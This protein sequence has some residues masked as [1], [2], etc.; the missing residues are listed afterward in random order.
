MTMKINESWVLLRPEC[1]QIDQQRSI[2][3]Q[4][5]QVE[6]TIV[7][8]FDNRLDNPAVSGGNEV[9]RPKPDHTATVSDDPADLEALAV[10][11]RVHGTAM[12]SLVIH[13]DLNEAGV[14]LF[15]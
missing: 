15:L 1:Q 13:G 14:D 6:S 4:V 7:A 12:A 8:I 9:R 5:F 2:D 10:G 11:P 3:I